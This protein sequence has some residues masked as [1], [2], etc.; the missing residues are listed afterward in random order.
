MRTTRNP[1]VQAVSAGVGAAVI[2]A[3]LGVTGVLLDARTG[4]G[5]AAVS[6]VA[7]A[8]IYMFYVRNGAVEKAGYAALIFVIAIAFIVPALLISQQQTQA[9]ETKSQYDETLHRGAALFGQYC[10]S[11]HGYQGQGLSG[12]KLNNNTAVNKLSKDQIYSII[13][14]GIP[15]NTDPS[16]Y[17]MPAWGAPVGPLTVD[18]I[19]YLV[20]LIQSSNKDYL[21]TQGLASTN[22]F[23]YVRETLTAAQQK[24]FDKQQ[25]SGSKPDATTFADLTGQATVAIDAVDVPAN[26]AQWSWEAV[27]AKSAAGSATPNITVKAGTTIL[28]GNKSNQIHNVF[29]GTSGTPDKGFL[30]S[31]GVLG[32]N[33]TDTYKVTLTTPGNYPYYCGL[34][35]A[36]IGYITV[37]P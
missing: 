15:D 16:K 7:S 24:E 20:A 11:C 10:A 30:P 22:G 5:L 32:A 28:F 27:G 6:L 21:K 31:P 25:K 19:N 2:F 3:L 13:T 26:G 37:V 23:T 8:L 14:G 18:D 12:P 4:F 29:Q 36:M 35:P 17:L 33:S 34:H 9:M 1:G